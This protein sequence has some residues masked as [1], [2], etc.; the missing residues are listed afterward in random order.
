MPKPSV[1]RRWL[2]PFFVGDGGADALIY[3][4]GSRSRFTLADSL[5][6]E[7]GTS[8]LGAAARRRGQPEIVISPRNNRREPSRS[9]RSP[10]P[11]M[12]AARHSAYAS[13]THCN[14]ARG[15]IQI[16]ADTR[17]RDI[18]DRHIQ[19]NEEVASRGD[20][21]RPAARLMH[22]RRLAP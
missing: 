17:Q 8:S 2:H 18:D 14:C 20:H 6:L 16:R 19:K 15:R 5:T 21:Q 1:L 10:A 11:S 12:N 13:T 9:T 7:S 4:D 3:R 22:A